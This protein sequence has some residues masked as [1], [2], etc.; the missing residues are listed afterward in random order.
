LEAKT[1]KQTDSFD[2]KTKALNE[3]EIINAL[4]E[5]ILN[6][7][8]E[9][10]AF[11]NGVNKKNEMEY[12]YFTKDN[13]IAYYSVPFKEKNNNIPIDR[14][15]ERVKVE[16]GKLY[17][18]NKESKRFEKANIIKIEQCFLCRIGYFK[19]KIIDK[20]KKRIIFNVSIANINNKDKLDFIKRMVYGK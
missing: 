3:K 8:E 10:Y 1:F 16:N 19:R 5:S 11:F 17:R 2:W 6:L 7:N 12:V 18:W 15:T 13:Y 4:K 14:F 20:L 9:N